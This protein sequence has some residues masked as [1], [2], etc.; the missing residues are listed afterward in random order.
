MSKRVR[1]TGVLVL[2]GVAAFCVVGYW[3]A[4]EAGANALWIRV[5]CRVSALVCV[6]GVARLVWSRK[7]R[8]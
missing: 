7:S 5:L 1:L 2:L 4:S 8:R 3:S 6:V